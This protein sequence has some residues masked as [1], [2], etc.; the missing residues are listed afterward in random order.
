MSVVKRILEEQMYGK[1][2]PGAGKGGFKTT[3]PW[4]KT[5]SNWIQEKRLPGEWTPKGVKNVLR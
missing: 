5:K 3:I 2:K 4:P 1:S